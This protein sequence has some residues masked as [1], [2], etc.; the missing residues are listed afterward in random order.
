MLF[1]IYFMLTLLVVCL[2]ALGT[3][4]TRSYRGRPRYKRNFNKFS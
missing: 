4:Y 1:L 3:I 2:V